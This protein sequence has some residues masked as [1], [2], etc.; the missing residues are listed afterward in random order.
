MVKSGVNNQRFNEGH[1][2]LKMYADT[3]MA[4]N[5]GSKRENTVN[6]EEGK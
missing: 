4:E 6:C 2:R 5:N 1:L 3:P